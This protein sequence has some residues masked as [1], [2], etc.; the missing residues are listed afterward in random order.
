MTYIDGIVCAVPTAKKAEYKAH[1]EEAASLFK[2]YGALSITECWGDDIPE[3]K[4][5][6]LHTAVMRKPEE[7]VVLS[8]ITWP[9][10]SDRDKGWQD[11]MQ[12]PEMAGQSLPFDGSRMIFGGFDVLLEA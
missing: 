2:K 12:C 3:G 6:S 9:S 4:T 7:T 5:N 1:A 10:K 11:I 8:W